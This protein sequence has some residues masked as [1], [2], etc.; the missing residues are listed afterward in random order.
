MNGIKFAGIFVEVTPNGI[1]VLPPGHHIRHP[2]HHACLLCGTETAHM[3]A[4][5]RDTGPAGMCVCYT[6]LAITYVT[7]APTN[8]NARLSVHVRYTCTRP[9]AQP[10]LPQGQWT[11]LLLHM[12]DYMA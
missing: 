10:L 12:F 9:A 1:H 2:Y 6:S 4:C 3:Y 7:I 11:S 8:R 5:C